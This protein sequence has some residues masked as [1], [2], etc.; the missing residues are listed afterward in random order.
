MRDSVICNVGI[1]LIIFIGVSTG[2]LALREATL[3]V[4]HE[5]ESTMSMTSDTDQL[6]STNDSYARAYTRNGLELS[7]L[8][9]IPSI[10]SQEF[11]TEVWRVGDH[12]I[13]VEMG[14]QL[15]ASLISAAKLKL[16]VSLVT[17]VEFPPVKRGALRG[18]AP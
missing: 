11:P 14:T 18:E 9:G 6:P 7:R 17:R 12:H 8:Q 1:P 15:H 16:S 3:S 13:K 10:V 4:E 5:K 2:V